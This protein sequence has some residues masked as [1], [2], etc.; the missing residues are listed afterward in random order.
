MLQAVMDRFADLEDWCRKVRGSFSH[1]S[2][3]NT[4]LA[5]DAVGVRAFTWRQG[6]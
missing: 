1:L 6:H 5:L 3:D 2:Y 4:R